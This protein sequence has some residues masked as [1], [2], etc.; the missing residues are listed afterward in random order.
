M[1]HATW[2]G[3]SYEV[4]PDTLFCSI[5]S[6]DWKRFPWELVEHIQD[7]C[8]FR[9]YDDWG[10]TYSRHKEIQLV[11]ETIES[12]KNNP[13]R[14]HIRGL[15]S[16]ESLEILQE[17]YR[18]L[19]YENSTAKNYSLPHDVLL[20]VSLTLRHILWCEKDKWF[21]TGKKDP[22]GQ[23]LYALIPPLR[24]PSDLRFLQQSTRMWMISG[25]EVLLW[26]EVYINRILQHQILT[27]FQFTQLVSFRWKNYGFV[28][29]ETT[30]S[31]PFPNFPV[32]SEDR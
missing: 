1:W 22:Q 2:N 32:I 28:G 27:V 18:S 30:I 17:Y 31:L 26:D 23:P 13:R 7:S 5:L 15:S 29:G 20:T 4:W 21:L 3:I 12:L 16:L 14:I 6:P 24:T 10:Q 8:K 11:E 25:I 9:G 19:G